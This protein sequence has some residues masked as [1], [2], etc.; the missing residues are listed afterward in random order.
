MGIKDV[1]MDIRSFWSMQGDQ[2]AEIER[3]RFPHDAYPH[4]YYGPRSSQGGFFDSYQ[5]HTQLWHDLRGRYVD[6]ENMDDYPEIAA[7]HDMYADEATQPDFLRN[8]QIWVEAQNVNIASD[9]NHLLHKTLDVGN[10]IWE[11]TRYLCKYGSNFERMFINGN[12]VVATEPLPAPLTQSVDDEFGSELGYMTSLT[13]DFTVDVNQF[14]GLLNK[15]GASEM[16]FRGL[17]SA[18][19]MIAFEPWE[20][21]HFRLRGKDRMTKY[22]FGI[23]E[24]VRWLYRRLVMMEDAA[25]IH[26]LT[27]APSRYV[28][29][30]DVGNVPPEKAMGHVQKV[31]DFYKKQKLINPNTG[32]I[33]QSYNPMAM[34]EDF[35]IPVHR[36]R[37]ESVRV[38]TLMGPDYQAMEDVNYFRKKLGRGLKIPNF[39]R[40]DD[41][42]GRPLSQE[43]FRFAA[44]VMRV[45]RAVI[46]GFK[47]I[48][49]IHLIATGRDP[50]DFPF[51]IYMTVPSA[52][53]ELARIEVISAKAD[54]MNSLSENISVR[55]MLV[56]FFGF[57]EEEA[58][59]L[60]VHR[61]EEIDFLAAAELDRE[62]ERERITREINSM[63]ESRQELVRDMWAAHDHQ[64]HIRGRFSGSLN[65]RD[66]NSGRNDLSVDEF[67][68]MLDKRDKALLGK[69]DRLAN[70]LETISSSSRMRSH[71]QQ[72]Q[73]RGD[74]FFN[75]PQ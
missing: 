32:K 21:S 56:N 27:R 3:A 38:D 44:A 58:V 4:N 6:Y 10:F 71:Q 16:N 48:C 13:G 63:D 61:Q 65:E 17:T 11:L 28:F 55:W 40:D 49:R 54:I 52:I 57:S 5:R 20:V 39:G 9:L 47:K 30:V 33:T 14:R 70:R 19:T 37:G 59:T 66:F 68:R 67:R 35:F 7:A 50:K 24:P 41:V 8:Q 75:P 1:W 74:W 23:G 62:L 12:G 51:E 42:Q 26:K 34:D 15:T 64:R 53:I 69:L 18:S 29:Y 72:K 43:D 60:M 22:G 31:K 73:S 25:V 45:Q 2:R 36:E 46:E